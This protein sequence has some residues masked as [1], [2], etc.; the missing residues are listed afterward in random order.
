MWNGALMKA[1]SKSIPTLCLSTGEAELA[2][3]VRGAT[4]GE[5][6]VSVLRDFGLEAKL[7]LESDASAVI[8][9]TQ[10][11]GLGKIRHLSVADLWIQQRIRSGAIKVT[12]C[13]GYRMLRI[14]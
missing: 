9:I 11:Q 12:K 5:G 4:E 2:A 7:R 14:S 1:W 6:L 8:G 13:Q 3:M 10:R